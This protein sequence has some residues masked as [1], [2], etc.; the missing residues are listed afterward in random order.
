M[1][2]KILKQYRELK[3]KSKESN[4]T[5]TEKENVK[6]KNTIDFLINH[7]Y[8]SSFEVSKGFMYIKSDAFDDFELNFNDEINSISDS[9]ENEN[10]D[11]LIDNIKTFIY[12][13]KNLQVNNELN[14]CLD[15]S[16]QLELSQWLSEIKLYSKQYLQDNI[17]LDDICT[18]CSNNRKKTNKQT[19][20]N[21]MI[22]LLKA[23]E[24]DLNKTIRH[25]K[26]ANI[27]I[28][29][30]KMKPKKIFISHSQDDEKYTDALV[31]LLVS[32][33]IDTTNLFCSSKNGYDIPLGESIYDFLRNCFTEC[34]LHVIFIH[35]KNFYSSAVSLNEMGAAWITGT[36][37]T[38]ILL[39]NFDFKDMDGVVKPDAIAIK[40]DSETKT[41]KHLLNQLSD[42]I[43]QEF[44]LKPKIAS[45]WEDNRDEF[46]ENVRN[47]S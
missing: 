36:K 30:D 21:D 24:N 20:V 43:I 46:L 10:N 47:L 44:N 16:D 13:G 19:V 4:I 8:V 32:L 15:G 7:E 42:I 33:G 28:K 27:I 5:L 39:P 12:T 45:I 41:V 6:F 38:S 34:E 35:S 9:S 40:L 31:K 17:L 26:Y 29:D 25:D 22:G 23:I 2:K 11:Y 18:I 3:E 14:L 37:H 1:T